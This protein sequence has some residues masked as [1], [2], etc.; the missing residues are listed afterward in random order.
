MRELPQDDRK[1]LLADINAKSGVIWVRQMRQWVGDAE[2]YARRVADL[3]DEATNE[4]RTL[5]VLRAYGALDE[6]R[7]AFDRHVEGYRTQYAGEPEEKLPPVVKQTQLLVQELEGALTSL[8]D[9]E[10]A[11]LLY[12]RDTECHPTLDRYRLRRKGDGSLKEKFEV[13]GRSWTVEDFDKAM[14]RILQV[15]G[16]EEAIMIGLARK[17]AAPLSKASLLLQGY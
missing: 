12:R 15:E 3:G 10:K 13:F 4:E 17:L 1:R 16:S 2:Y 14:S 6:V 8:T 5:F 11:Y 7:E 9:E